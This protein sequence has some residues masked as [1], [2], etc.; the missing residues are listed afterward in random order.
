MLKTTRGVLFYLLGRKYSLKICYSILNLGIIIIIKINSFDSWIIFI[1][2]Y[3]YYI[4]SF[5]N[6][7]MV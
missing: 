5:I 7:A 3:I 4:I 1:D 6:S 2:L